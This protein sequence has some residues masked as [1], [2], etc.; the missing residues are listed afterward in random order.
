MS[1]EEARN[2][3]DSAILEW[4]HAIQDPQV[5]LPLAPPPLVARSLDRLILEVQAAMPCCQCFNVPC[6]CE[7]TYEDIGR[8]HDSC[9]AC[10]ARAELERKKVAVP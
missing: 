7:T 9:P 4:A 3:T 1:I 2:R 5:R 6:C 10:A 8:C